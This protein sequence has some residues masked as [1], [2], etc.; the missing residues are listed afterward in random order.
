MIRPAVAQEW[1]LPEIRKI[2]I[3][4]LNE[5]FWLGVDDYKRFWLD[6]LVLFALLVPLAAVVVAGVVYNSRFIHLIFP[7]VSGVSLVAPAAAVVFYQESRWREQGG[8]SAPM[9]RSGISVAAIGRVALLAALLFGVLAAWL[10]AADAIYQSSF[11]GVVAL[12]AQQLWS[13]VFGTEAGAHMALTGAVVGFFFA[14]LVFCL[15][16]TSFPMLID[17]DVSVSMA[18]ATSI[19]VVLEN[20]RIMAYW[21]IFVAGSLFV[22]TVPLLLGHAIVLP[23]LGH[24][25]WHLYRRVVRSGLE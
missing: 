3:S 4:D 13:Q 21:A 16:V 6:S 14:V 5:A 20:P 1:V 19:K 23:L 10:L 15:S 12:S 24:A 18:M 11:D 22:A 7:L 9:S 8:M 2:G 17:R 25:S